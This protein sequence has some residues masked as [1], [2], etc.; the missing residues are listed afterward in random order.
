MPG[1]NAVEETS[2]HQPKAQAPAPSPSAPSSSIPV[3]LSSLA[4]LLAA[5]ALAATL[6]SNRNMDAQQST[7]NIKNKLSSIEN[8][9]DHMEALMATDKHS[10][11]KAQL[12]KTLLNLHELSRLADKETKSEISRAETILLRLS[13]PATKIKAKVDLK[14]A[15]QPAQQHEPEASATAPSIPESTDTSAP[16][17][18]QTTPAPDQASVEPESPSKTTA[19]KPVE[20]PLGKMANSPPPDAGAETTPAAPPPMEQ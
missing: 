9:V 3:L 4:L 10:L 20:K 8:R 18:S 14:S 1:K 7:D 6:I 11:V 2:N 17:S 5:L 15:E 13:T 16:Q 19:V 12:K